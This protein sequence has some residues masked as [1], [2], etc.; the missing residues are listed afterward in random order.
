M[1]KTKKTAIPRDNP[2]YLKHGFV[3][4]PSNNL[5]V[6]LLEPTLEQQ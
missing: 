4:P 6:Y 5:C 3:S 1:D 2:D